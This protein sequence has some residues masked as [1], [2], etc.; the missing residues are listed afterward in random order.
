MEEYSQNQEEFDA[1]FHAVIG[2]LKSEDLTLYGSFTTMTMKMHVIK[3]LLTL[4]LWHSKS[5]YNIA[6]IYFVCIYFVFWIKRKG[7]KFQNPNYLLS[8]LFW[9]SDKPSY[10]WSGTSVVL[11]LVVSTLFS[12]F[13]VANSALK[14]GKLLQEKLNSMFSNF[15]I[16]EGW[17]SFQVVTPI[18]NIPTNCTFYFFHFLVHCVT[19]P[20]S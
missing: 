6:A 13:T 7:N 19:Q 20:T 14:N 9:S 3:Y 10:I 11:S 2:S 12:H 1:A 15:F 18:K 8:S 5:S 16:Y 4:C 17:G